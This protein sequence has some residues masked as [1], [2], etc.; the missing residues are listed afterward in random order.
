MKKG[1]RM[2]LASVLCAGALCGGAMAAGGFVEPP[3]TVQVNGETLVFTDAKPQLKNERTF[4]PF[5]AV[6]NALGADVRWNEAEPDKVVALRG[7]K[8]LTMIIGSTQVTLEEDGEVKTFTMDVAPYLDP[9]TNRTYV[10][11]FFA[12]DA[13]DCDVGWDPY[14]FT[15]IIVDTDALVKDA[16]AGKRYTWMEKLAEYS[17]EKTYRSG[18]WDLEATGTGKVKL[19]GAEMPMTVTAKGAVADND[20]MSIDMN[21]TMDMTRLIQLM[22]LMEKTEGGATAGIDMDKVRA[23]AKDGVKVEMRGDLS[24]GTVY[25]RVAGTLTEGA[26]VDNQVWYSVPMRSTLDRMGSPVDWISASELQNAILAADY[27]AMAKAVLAERGLTDSQNSYAECKAAVENLFTAFSDAAFTRNGDIVTTVW[28]F[29]GDGVAADLELKLTVKRE[30]VS[31]CTLTTREKTP[32]LTSS[33][34]VT[35]TRPGEMTGVLTLDMS[36]LMTEEMTLTVKRSP[37][38][39]TPQTRLPAGAVVKPYEGLLPVKQ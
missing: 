32:R 5:Y 34:A 12:A 38:E 6:F 2:L 18:T 24:S 35:L 8:T 9:A 15:A 29:D 13:L 36:P 3:V 30:K 22:E 27:H 20:K 26:G 39:T 25:Q 19:L 4:L 10:P 37:G 23:M 16:M 21:M 33:M 1:I 7:G 14:T 31:L 28:A 17:G 11:V